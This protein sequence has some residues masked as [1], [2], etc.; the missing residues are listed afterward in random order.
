MNLTG[1]AKKDFEKW[2]ELNHEA[3]VLRS[4]D[5]EFHLEGFY[6]LPESMQFGVLVDFF[7][8][9]GVVMEFD[10]FGDTWV[11]YI[12]G[13]PTHP[14]FYWPTRQEARKQALIK[15]NEIYNK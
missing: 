7:D 13:D 12:N 10:N 9:A 1:K 2:Y 5:D 3:I 8:S 15:A 4:I 6:E 14:I 11:S